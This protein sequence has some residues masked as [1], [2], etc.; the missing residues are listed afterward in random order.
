M[1]NENREGVSLEER[2]ESERQQREEAEFKQRV[3]KKVRIEAKRYNENLAALKAK[4]PA[5]IP[6]PGDQAANELPSENSPV[7]NTDSTNT[8]ASAFVTRPKEGNR[9]IR[10]P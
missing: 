10:S 4:Y 5:E 6:T 1:E 8:S 3:R 7:S 2:K 9:N